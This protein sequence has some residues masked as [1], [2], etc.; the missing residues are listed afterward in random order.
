MTGGEEL[1]KKT[2]EHLRSGDC[3]HPREQNARLCTMLSQQNKKT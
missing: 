1:T 2:I 3:I